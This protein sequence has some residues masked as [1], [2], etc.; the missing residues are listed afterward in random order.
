M[1]SLIRVFVL[2]RRPDVSSGRFSFHV[3]Y[4]DTNYAIFGSFTF[5]VH[6]HSIFYFFWVFYITSGAFTTMSATLQSYWKPWSYR[7]CPEAY[8]RM[9]FI[10][11]WCSSASDKLRSGLFQAKCY[12]HLTELMYFLPCFSYFRLQR[13]ARDV[14]SAVCIFFFR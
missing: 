1:I 9:P 12:P 5:T 13:S 8:I 6:F 14:A 3:R 7:A 4:F 2:S 11:R 10:G